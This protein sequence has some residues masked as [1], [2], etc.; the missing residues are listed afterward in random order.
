MRKSP[1]IF[2]VLQL[3]FAAAAGMMLLLACWILPPQASVQTISVGSVSGQAG[4]A[5]C[6]VFS[7][8]RTLPSPSSA[9]K[10]LVGSSPLFGRFTGTTAQSD[11]SVPFMPAV[12]RS[13]FSGRSAPLSRADGSEV[14][15]FSYMKFS[16]VPGI[17]DY[18]GPPTCSRWRMPW[19]CLP[20]MSTG[21]AP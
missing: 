14:S 15:R 10:L 1:F 16:S 18:A 17:Y 3:P 12:R 4:T 20:R 8:V 13:A 9:V 11:P 7:S 2:Q 19:F 21:S 6:L 5:V